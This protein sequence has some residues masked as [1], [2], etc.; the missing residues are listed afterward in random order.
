MNSPGKVRRKPGKILLI[1]ATIGVVL[2]ISLSALLHL[3]LNSN[4]FRS[5]LEDTLESRL[6]RSVT[7]GS[8]S[9]GLWSGVV[10]RALVITE[11][12]SGDEFIIL[13]RV[14]ATWSIVG[15]IARRTERV[16]VIEPKIF[17]T[18]KEGSATSA[19][20]ERPALPISIKRMRIEGGEVTVKSADT[21]PFTVGP[22]DL[23][24]DEIAEGMGRAE[25]TAFLP[26]LD[27]ELSLEAT[28]DLK[29]L[30]IYS[31]HIDLGS[32]DLETLSSRRLPTL[33]ER[34]IRGVLR[35]T[36]DIA[37]D[38]GGGIG[39]EYTGLFENVG[40]GG[41]REVFLGDA[42]GELKALVSRS[43]D[44]GHILVTVEADATTSVTEDEGR[45]KVAFS[46]R[47]DLKGRELTIEEASFSSTFFGSISAT[48]N[49]RDFPS[50]RAAYAIDLETEKV[51]LAKINSQLPYPPW[52]WIRGFTVQRY[53]ERKGKRRG[54]SCYTC[55]VSIGDY[56]RRP[57]SGWRFD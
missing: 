54:F 39:I 42:S 35:S 27:T 43:R 5:L 55:E 14:E 20:G 56:R 6:E 53:N 26:E 11:H 2:C 15:L 24:F 7:I 16:I 30:D 45:H 51:S 36:L 18:L 12:G 32:I 47:Y 21:P 25:L 48:G 19:G 17:L 57:F 4:S 23:A 34:M 8:L 41:E 31:G 52:L 38:E 1:V 50:D 13:P 33:K 3:Y 10:M 28:V 9:V 44:F 40:M 37:K 46:G 49:L 22:I 29:G